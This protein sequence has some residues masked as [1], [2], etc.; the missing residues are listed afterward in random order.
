MFLAYEKVYLLLSYTFFN[1]IVYLKILTLLNQQN[2]ATDIQEAGS[3]GNKTWGCGNPLSWKLLIIQS[4][5]V[6][7]PPWHPGS[8]PCQLHQQP[9]SSLLLVNFKRK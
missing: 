9:Q 3:N 7:Q 4:N 8:N 2:F 6:S 1:Q 5:Q